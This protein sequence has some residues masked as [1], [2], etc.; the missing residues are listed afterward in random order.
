MK[1]VLIVDKDLGFLFWV[2][3]LLAGANYQPWPAC[4]A[5]D[6]INLMNS[7]RTVPLDLLI[8]NASMRG[9]SRLIAHFR[10]NRDDL[11]VI[12][13]DGQDK[14]LAGVNAWSERP[15]SGNARARQKWLRVIERM[16]GSY[17]RAA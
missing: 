6:A 11:K 9:A 8:V 3:E 7:K 2:G 14:A 17:K 4:N 10:R 15:E 16:L 13:V 12:A 5:T 1:N